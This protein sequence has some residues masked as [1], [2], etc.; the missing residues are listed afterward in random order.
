VPGITDTPMCE[1]EANMAEDPRAVWDAWAQWALAEQA[2][3]EL[4]LIRDA[5]FMAGATLVTDGGFT[6]R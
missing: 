2:R 6:T 4:F 3:A 5:T 1:T